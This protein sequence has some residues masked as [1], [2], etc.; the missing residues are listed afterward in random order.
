MSFY[1]DYCARTK[2][3]P[4]TFHGAPCK[5]CGQTSLFE[6]RVP[7][8]VWFKTLSGGTVDAYNGSYNGYCVCLC[9]H[10]PG[11]EVQAHFYDQPSGSTQA[12]AKCEC[13]AKACGHADNTPG[14]SRWCPMFSDKTPEKEDLVAKVRA[15]T[16]KPIHPW[17]SWNP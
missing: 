10:V 12:A 15:T 5:S 11:L 14:H 17:Y 6:P 7:G 2:T 1:D 8:V 13:G 4:L 16:K 9:G 3:K